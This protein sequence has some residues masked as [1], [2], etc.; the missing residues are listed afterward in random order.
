MN[1][2]GPL[3]IG[4][5]NDIGDGI[6]E[7]VPPCGICSAGGPA[8]GTARGVCAG[9]DTKDDGCE[10][11]DVLVLVAEPVRTRLAPRVGGAGA[12]KP[13]LDG[14][15]VVTE[16]VLKPLAGG[17]AGGMGALIITSGVLSLSSPPLAMSISSSAISIG[18]SSVNADAGVA[19]RAAE[20]D[21]GVR[22]GGAVCRSE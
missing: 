2:D 20:A 7:A 17:A 19:N 10:G 3:S 14:L 18:A 16:V 12:I 8:P 6:T 4:D 5:G 21:G 22:I 11:E 9:D 1:C 15:G 13:S